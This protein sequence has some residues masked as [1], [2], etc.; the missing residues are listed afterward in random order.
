MLI[1]SVIEWNYSESHGPWDLSTLALHATVPSHQSLALLSIKTSLE[2]FKLP[3][4]GKERA[5]EDK[6]WKTDT[7]AKV[8]PARRRSEQ[9]PLIMCLWIEAPTPQRKRQLPD[10][11]PFSTLALLFF[12]QH[13][14]LSW[15][16]YISAFLIFTG[17]LHV[18]V[19]VKSPHCFFSS[20]PEIKTVRIELR[21]ALWPEWHF[22]LWLRRS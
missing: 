11:P 18:P 16:S 21:S 4:R 15:I 13:T 12:V 9:H 2:P 10:W 3:Q 6:E 17:G 7:L 5:E 1:S 19:N 20:R 8:S 14:L 22:P